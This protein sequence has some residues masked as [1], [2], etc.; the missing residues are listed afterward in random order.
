[1]ICTAMVEDDGITMEEACKHIFL[2][3]SRGLVVKGRSTGGI[4]KEKE[5]YAQEGFKEVKDLAEIVA[6]VK[7]T[8]I[9]GVSGQP[10]VFTKEVCQNMAKNCEEPMIFPMSNP[11]KKA[12]CSAADA[13]AWTDGK[14]IFASGSP[15]PELMVNGQKVVPAQGNNAYVFPGVALA[16]IATK[17]LRCPDNFFVMGAKVLAS[18]VTD[19]MMKSKSL[20]PPLSDLQRI[21]FEI[22]VKVAEECYKKQYATAIEP[23]NVRDLVRSVVWDHTT[24]PNYSSND[25]ANLTEEYTGRPTVMGGDFVAKST[26]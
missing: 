4:S 5:P 16:L 18:L 25:Q 6:L 11:T 13:F 9:M 19:E 1:M 8:C 20:Y 21:S 26:V 7:A 24:Y 22:A 2:V 17:S 23:K 12:E 10:K 15:F 3:D 14:C